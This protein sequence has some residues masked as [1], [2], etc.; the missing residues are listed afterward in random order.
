MSN[1]IE[2]ERVYIT[3]LNALKESLGAAA[4][5]IK[6]HIRTL[7]LDD[8]LTDADTSQAID[9]SLDD[10]GNA[11]PAQARPLSAHT[12]VVTP[13]GGT[14]LSALT[15]QIGDAADPDEMLTATDLFGDARNSWTDAGGVGTFGRLEAAAYVPLATYTST[16]ANMSAVTGR[17]A[18]VIAYYKM[19]SPYVDGYVAT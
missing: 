19:L 5:A 12:L 17:V 7:T 2:D 16:G 15:V 1:R 8:S 4:G 9:I 3:K 6:F 10:D 18:H 13:V 14:S 11:F